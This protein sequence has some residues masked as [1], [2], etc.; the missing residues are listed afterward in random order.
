MALFM[1]QIEDNMTKIT[2]ETAETPAALAHG[3][4]GRQDLPKDHG[5]L[6]RFTSPR[7]VSFWG[8][9]T[10][11]PL[12]IAFISPDLRI[13]SIKSITPM[14]TKS[15]YSDNICDMAIETNAGFFSK[16]NIR[17]GHRIEIIQNKRGEIRE[18]L[19]REC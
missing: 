2:V 6:F 1:T 18:V 11:I 4:M 3:L 8:K 16:H 14:S 10:Y 19:F 15:V 13:S 17:E 9:N 5:M 7:P 12:D